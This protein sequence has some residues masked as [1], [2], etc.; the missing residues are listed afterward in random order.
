[1][2]SNTQEGTLINVVQIAAICHA[3]NT[4]FRHALGESVDPGDFYDQELSLKRS[5]VAGVVFALENP[6]VT[7]D[8]MHA[9][10]C[11]AREADGWVYGPVKDSVAKTHPCLVPYKELE[12]DQRVKDSLF[13]NIVRTFDGKRVF[14]PGA[15]ELEAMLKSG[16]LDEDREASSTPV[17]T[18][19]VEETQSPVD[20]DPETTPNTN[21]EGEQPKEEAPANDDRALQNPPDELTKAEGNE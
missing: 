17:E 12:H 11:R 7:P 18:P 10:W 9:N 5:T 15:D 6:G 13:S 16:H 20:G 21:P 3:A 8:T 19:V 14:L 2:L 4:E 1:M